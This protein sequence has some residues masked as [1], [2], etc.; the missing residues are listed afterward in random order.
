MKVHETSGRSLTKAITFRLLVLTVDSLIIYAITGRSDITV[1]VVV[2]S[3]IS[4]T[5][6]YFLHERAWNS[7][8]WGRKKINPNK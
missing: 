8:H 1:G 7:I 6:L 5:V 3:N 4:S 2:L